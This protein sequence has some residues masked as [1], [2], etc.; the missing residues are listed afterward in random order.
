[1]HQTL[2]TKTDQNI[3]ALGDC[4]ACA[5]PEGGGDVPPRAKAAHQQARFLARSLN[6]GLEGDRL[7]LYNYMD[8]GSLV[9][10]GQNTATGSLT[11]RLFRNQRLSRIW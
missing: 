2:Q 11:G 7:P 6:L 10:L 8:F 3:F 9:S 4:A 1:V 5:W